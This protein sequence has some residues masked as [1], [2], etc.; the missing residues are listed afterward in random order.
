MYASASVGAFFIFHEGLVMKKVKIFVLW[1]FLILITNMV[2]FFCP[3]CED[4]A[5][6][7]T[8]AESEFVGTWVL[9]DI[10]YIDYSSTN[11][12]IYKYPSSLST[13]N[14][15]CLQYLDRTK[16]IFKDIKKTGEIVGTLNVGDQT[17]DFSWHG[18]NLDENVPRVDFVKK[19]ELLT[20]VPKIDSTLSISVSYAIIMDDGKMYISPNTYMKYIFK[21]Q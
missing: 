11:N 3:A 4:T 5:E 16:I 9:D 19:F 15:L 1:L 18:W 17:Y 10:G 12:K 13:F 8:K 20:Y 21:K 6:P 7:L 14:S 2:M